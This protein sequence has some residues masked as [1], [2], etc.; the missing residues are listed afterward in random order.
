MQS[1]QKF[2]VTTFRCRVCGALVLISELRHPLCTSASQATL[3]RFAQH[4]DHPVGCCRRYIVQ[5]HKYLAVYGAVLNALAARADSREVATFFTTS[6]LNILSGEVKLHADLL[7]QWGVS[8]EDV[9]S[10]PMQPACLMYTSY[11]Q[12]TAAN[13]PFF[14]GNVA[15]QDFLLLVS[16]TSYFWSVHCSLWF[17]YLFGGVQAQCTGEPLIQ[18]VRKS[19]NQRRYRGTAY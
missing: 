12:A 3:P 13:R 7:R 6:A 17:L 11:L 14:E 10:E 18:L 8:E 9:L 19:E 4:A 15:S 16:C 1:T 2:S 5:D